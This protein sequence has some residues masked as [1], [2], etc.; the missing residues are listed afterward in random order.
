MRSPLGSRASFRMLR[1]I[2]FV[3]RF[4]RH[5]FYRCVHLLGRHPD[6]G[7]IA[8]RAR[9]LVPAPGSVPIGFVER[10]AVFN[11]VSESSNNRRRMRE[12]FGG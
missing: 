10:G 4:V 2:I 5:F 6:A 11:D 1:V 8:S 3:R 7:G 9:A 12:R